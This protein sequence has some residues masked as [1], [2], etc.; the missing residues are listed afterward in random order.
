MTLLYPAYDRNETFYW[1][2][3]VLVIGYV[4]G[5][6]VYIGVFIQNTSMVYTWFANPGAPG[7]E[8]VSFRGTF[9]DVAIRLTIFS[10]VLALMIILCMVI[11]RGNYACSSLWFLLYV[12]TILMTII[13]FGATLASYAHCNGQNEYGNPCNDL[14]WCCAPEIYSN[15]ANRCPNTL[16]CDPAVTLGQLRANDDFLGLFWTNTILFIVF[17]LGFLIVS[18]YTNRN[19]GRDENEEGPE[20]EEDAF[21]KQAPSVNLPVTPSVRLAKR[22]HGLR[23]RNPK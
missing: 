8:L 13:G 11:Y 6:G 10:H 2:L 12:V 18:V 5:V 23:Q 19:E 14:K 15:P 1:F 7:S 3:W 21:E 9:T 17:Q 20:E 22:V 4:I 16:P